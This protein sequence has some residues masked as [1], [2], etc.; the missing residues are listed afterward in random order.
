MPLAKGVRLRGIEAR[1]GLYHVAGR[2]LHVPAAALDWS[3][4]SGRGDLSGLSNDKHPARNVFTEAYQ[5]IHH[6]SWQH[7]QPEPQHLGTTA[8]PGSEFIQLQVRE[9]ELEEEALVQGL[10]MLT[11]TGQ[12]GW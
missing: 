5:I 8:E 10:R 4:A 12:K 9:V 6:V 7:H 1:W 11:R 3:L 2:L